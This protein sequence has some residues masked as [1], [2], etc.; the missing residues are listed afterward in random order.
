MSSEG[1]LVMEKPAK[2][3]TLPT[4]ISLIDRL[5]NPEDNR[6]WAE[7]VS[8]YQERVVNVARGRGLAEHHARD[9]AQEV[10][11][12]VAVSIVNYKPTPVAG[13]FRSWLFKLTRWRAADEIRSLGPFHSKSVSN[14]SAHSDS[15]G[16]DRTATIER[17]PA[18]SEAQDAIEIESR[19]FLVEKLLE[20][21]ERHL[22]SKQ[23]QIFQMVVLD[24]VPVAKVAEFYQMTPTAV[25]TLKHRTMEKLRREI[26][27]INVA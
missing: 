26:G 20:R 7:F 21:V 2:T 19:Q 23:L 27:R 16:G 8:R 25:Y 6:S 13:S 10:F 4:R 9:V 18:P 24:E 22:T 5:R 15:C 1:M 12:R 11:K 17:I 3:D 14:T